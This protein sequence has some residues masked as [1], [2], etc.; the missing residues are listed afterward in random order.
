MV[1]EEG[2][3][4]PQFKPKAFEDN[5]LDIAIEACGVFGSDVHTMTGGW[6][7][8]KLFVCVRHH[9]V[10]QVVRAGP[11]VSAVRIGDRVV[12]GIQVGACLK[13]KNWKS[14]SENYCAHGVAE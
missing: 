3:L 1:N 9:I 14:D 4:F 7:D 12:V 5:D 8:A 2:V 6:R 10:G 13:S 11:K